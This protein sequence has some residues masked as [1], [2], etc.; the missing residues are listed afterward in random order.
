MNYH[1]DQEKTRKFLA[2][3][4]GE[5]GVGCSRLSVLAAA[6]VTREKL[7]AAKR[8]LIIRNVTTAWAAHE[9]WTLDALQTTSSDSVFLAGLNGQASIS[10]VLAQS[11][12]Y[13]TGQVGMPR[14]CY[15]DGGSM[16]A[17]IS[18]LTPHE[19]H[20]SPFLATSR[21][22]TLPGFLQ[23][24]RQL[25]MALAVGNGTGVE[26]E[27]HPSGWFA[28]IHGRKRWLLHPPAANDPGNLF[29]IS[30]QPRSCGSVTALFTSS[31]VCDQK[32]GD[33]LWL[34]HGWWHEVRATPRAH[35]ARALARERGSAS[36]RLLVSGA[37]AMPPDACRSCRL[38]PPSRVTCVDV[39][40]R[41]LLGGPRRR[42]LQGA[43]EP[44]RRLRQVQPRPRR[45]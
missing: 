11:G 35:G 42:Y 45:A 17:K 1:L 43:R 34:P 33:V 13:H 30:G 19:R 25:Y 3:A 2:A 31:I 32:E 39:Q 8:P 40:S 6:D 14:D 38:T 36:G 44:A 12:K 10:Q 41:L 27:S 7:L 4:A 28:A 16:Y 18:T 20:Y 22:Y 9:E 23:P 37:A 26:D 29:Q 21:D 24:S 5:G 15:T